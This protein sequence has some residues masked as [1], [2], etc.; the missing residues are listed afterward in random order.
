MFAPRKLIHLYYC[1]PK[2]LRDSGKS[3]ECESLVI[4]LFGL[5]SLHCV[6]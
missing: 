6:M 3:N 1:E 5:L 2:K 4:D